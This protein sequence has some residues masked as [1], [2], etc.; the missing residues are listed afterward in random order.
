MRRRRTPER[1]DGHWGWLRGLGLE[2]YEKA[3]RENEIDLR[4]PPELTANA[5]GHRRLLKAIADLA[6]G[7]RA[8]RAGG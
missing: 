8:C 7:F 5:I 4:L 3:F 6:T 2:R 1:H